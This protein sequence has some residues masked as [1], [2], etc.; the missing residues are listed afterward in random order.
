MYE[1]R[2]STIKTI[3]FP[4]TTST[5]GCRAV[6]NDGGNYVNLN[7]SPVSKLED[8]SDTQPDDTSTNYRDFAHWSG[9]IF[10]C[11]KSV[12]SVLKHMCWWQ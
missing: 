12:Y 5:R 9:H 8:V 6:T 2:I 3:R 4:K 7:A 1:G 10:L 11:D